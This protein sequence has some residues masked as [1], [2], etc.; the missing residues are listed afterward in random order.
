MCLLSND[1]HD[2][3]LNRYLRNNGICYINLSTA[4]LL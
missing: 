3:Q 2:R 4:I 1:I